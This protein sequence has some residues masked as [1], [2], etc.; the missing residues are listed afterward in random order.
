MTVKQLI[1]HLQQIDPELHVFTSGYEG[2]CE[3][4]VVSDIHNVK[5]IVLNANEEWYYGPHE[6]I[7]RI[8]NPRLLE[9]REVVKGIIL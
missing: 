7:D 8:D 3:D 5:E 2:G 4:I 9:G 6:E 1:E